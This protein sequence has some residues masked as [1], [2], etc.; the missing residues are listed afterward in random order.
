M[1]IKDVELQYYINNNKCFFVKFKNRK[2]QHFHYDYVIEN[3]HGSKLVRKW[4]I[5]NKPELLI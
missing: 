4:I 2:S 5:K 3:K 1:K